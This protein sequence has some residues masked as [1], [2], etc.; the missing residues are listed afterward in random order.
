MAY[1]KR[2]N[3]AN[4]SLCKV[5]IIINAIFQTFTNVIIP[6]LF[7]SYSIDASRSTSDLFPI[8]RQLPLSKRPYDVA[9]LMHLLNQEASSNPRFIP[10]LLEYMNAN[11]D[12]DVTSSDEENG[13]E[14][15]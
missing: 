10:L 8:S 14:E 6:Y 7:F 2:Y 4:N 5:Y 15:R 12:G 3:T 13:Y 9:P 1:A 11:A